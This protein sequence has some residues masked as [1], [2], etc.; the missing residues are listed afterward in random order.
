MRLLKKLSILEKILLSTILLVIVNKVY[1]LFSP[2]S[3]TVEGFNSPDPFKL[4]TNDSLYDSFYCSIYDEL[5]YSKK[6]V[7]FEVSEIIKETK[8]NKNR[9]VLDIGSGTGHSVGNLNYKGIPVIG[10]DKSHD[11]TRIAKKNYKNL[12]FFTGDAQD[13]NLFNNDMITHITC[14][15]YTIY[16]IKNKSIFFDNCNKWLMPGGYLVIHLVNKSKASS[17]ISASYNGNN[18]EQEV[19]FDHLKYTN[20][21][22]HD[23]NI[24][25]I[26]ETIRMNGTVRQNEHTLYIDNER[27][28]VNIARKYGFALI[29]KIDMKE[30]NYNYQY[31]YVFQKE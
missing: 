24:T 6:R 7:D 23:N 17:L 20:K 29:K 22:T 12:N 14:L 2:S 9:V 10:I 1:I 15:N 5:T 16:Y 19:P 26:T 11:M 25:T 18:G 13:P 4:K 21:T 27:D 31:L 28:V 30:C 8:M 3:I